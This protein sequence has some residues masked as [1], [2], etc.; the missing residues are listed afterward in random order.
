[1]PAPVIEFETAVA[2]RTEAGRMSIALI[3]G[4]ME[5]GPTE[6]VAVLVC[7]EASARALVATVGS[8]L[9]RTE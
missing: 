3:D 9:Q 4:S 8:A 2:S 5:V 7:T 6:A 1:M